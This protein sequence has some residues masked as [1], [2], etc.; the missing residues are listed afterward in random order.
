MNVEWKLLLIETQASSGAPGKV[1]NRKEKKKKKKQ[2]H[3]NNQPENKNKN[4]TKP[5]TSK[6]KIRQN[7]LFSFVL[8]D[9]H[10]EWHYL[11]NYNMLNRIL[12]T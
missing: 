3:K 9:F 12:A 11:C 5:I 1:S 4:L 2:Q 6:Q 8:A 10:P 7:N